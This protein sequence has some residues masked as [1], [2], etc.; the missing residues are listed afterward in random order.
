MWHTLLSS[1]KMR[2]FLVENRARPFGSRIVSFGATGFATDKFCC[3]ARS[4]LPPYLGVQVARHYL[5][6]E[7]PLLNREQIARAN[8]NG[9]LNVMMCFAGWDYDGLSR[10]QILAVRERQSEAFH[11]AHSGY[12]VKEFLADATGEEDL[13]WML[14]AGAHVRRDY[15]GYFQKH[16]VRIPKSSQR[17]QLVGLTKEEAFASPGRHLSS[18]FVYTP[19]R[20]NFNPSEQMLLNHSLMGET[21]EELA[22][23]L[24]I[25]TWT[26]KKRWHAIYQRVADV[27]AE[28]LLPPVT[29]T[30]D[31]T[32]RGAERRR[33]LLHYLRQ[34]LEELRPLSR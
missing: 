15:S 14:D 23:S 32:G 4:T 22:R 7:L 20:F 29:N 33:H 6:H 17:P 34:H 21:S 28:L 5:S 8:A 19:P 31:A 27:D 13:H 25:S 18:F 11:L 12:R 30:P 16:R 1:G 9:G 10:E 26:V 24:F 2:F 3:Q